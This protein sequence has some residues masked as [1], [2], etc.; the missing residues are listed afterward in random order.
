MAIGS[1]VSGELKSAAGLFAKVDGGWK[2]AKFG[3]VKV[4]GEW[5]QF[6]ADKLEDLFNRLDTTSGLGTADS[7]QAWNIV[8]SQWQ[9]NG[10]AAKTTGSK[11]DVPLAIVDA[12]F[13]D[14]DLEATELTPGTGVAI[15][16]NDANNWWAIVPY[17]NSVTTSFTYCAASHPQNYCISQCSVP[18]GS[19]RS[20]GGELVAWYDYTPVCSVPEIYVPGEVY[21]DTYGCDPQPATKVCDTCSREVIKK[22]PC[23][24]YGGWPLRCIDYDS[25]TVT[26]YYQCNCVTEPACDCCGPN[27]PCEHYSIDDGYYDCPGSVSYIETFAYYSCDS[28]NGYNDAWIDTPTYSCDPNVCPNGTAATGIRQVCDQYATG[29]TTTNYFYLQILKMEAGVISVVS[30]VDVGQRWSNL[31]ATAQDGNLTVTAYTDS[32]FTQVAGTYST[33]AFTSAGTNFG[34]VSIQSLFEDGRTIASLKVK[35]LGQ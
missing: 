4:A 11:N 26:E 25:I 12:G 6:W 23:L 17:Y 34:V 2:K 27:P 15:R 18:T 14:F 19:T 9:I 5:K 20:C 10:N 35:P 13:I 30:N 21:C 22:G 32:L 29:S 7:G 28:P 16:A 31:K 1:R 3:Y 33:S 24:K 8:R